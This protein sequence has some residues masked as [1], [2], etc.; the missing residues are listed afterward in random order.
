MMFK[1]VHSQFIKAISNDCAAGKDAKLV[2]HDHVLRQRTQIDTT[3]SWKELNLQPRG[4]FYLW[5]KEF[6]SFYY[7]YVKQNK[8]VT[9]DLPAKP[10]LAGEKVKN[11]KQIDSW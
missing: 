7:N 8:N 4:E 3:K 1:M 10:W 5:V 2:W 11:F 6:K 9:I